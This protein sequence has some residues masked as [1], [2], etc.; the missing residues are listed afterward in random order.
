MKI[1]E[2]TQTLSNFAPT[3]YQE[4]YDNI[5]LLIGD[6]NNTCSGIICT[7][8]V[9][10][11]VVKEALE[12][13]CNLIVAHHP[14][15]FKGLKRLNGYSDAE[16]AIIL[17][18]QHNIAIYA[19]HTNLD[20][21]LY[22]VN[23]KLAQKL[24]LLH[25]QV[26]LPKPNTLCKL[27]TFVPVAYSEKVRNALFEAGAGKIGGYS[28]CSFSV[29]GNGTFTAGEGTNPFVGKILER[30]LEKE[31]KV[32][33]I[34]PAVLQN[35]IIKALIN[36]HPYE[37]AAY[38]IIALQNE[39]PQVGS[40]IIGHLP[41]PKEAAKFLSALK[42]LVGVAVIKHSPILEK[43]V[44]KIAICGGAGSF[45]INQAIH[46]GADIFITA[47]LKYHEFFEANNHLIL[48]DIGHWESEQFTIDLLAEVLQTK[49]PTFAVLKSTVSTNPVHYFL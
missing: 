30:H 31:E 18:I 34:F 22:G 41:E 12:K 38:D 6:E 9:T 45:L 10:E 29:S 8:D 11:A 4:S 39:F 40:G 17:A 37:E 21:V 13:N 14:I 25:T 35:A 2:I 26:L 3:A 42:A 44:Q 32:E 28:D 48:A 49:F 46:A 33:V 23:S 27:Y 16:K 1:G 19:I 43:P 36:A 7:L 15:I 5:G 24:G 20:N 47:D